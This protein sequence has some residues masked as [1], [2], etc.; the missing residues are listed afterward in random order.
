MA[1]RVKETE[2]LDRYLTIGRLV[3]RAEQV[4]RADKERE[5][6][7]KLLADEVRRA[8]A[9]GLDKSTVARLVGVSRQR[10]GQIVPEKVVDLDGARDEDVAD[11]G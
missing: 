6:Q 11:A 4:A 9:M 10:I 5:I 7:H 8:V 1:S 3:E 2:S